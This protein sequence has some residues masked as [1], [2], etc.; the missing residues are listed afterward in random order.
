MR[1]VRNQYDP[2][3]KWC[4]F[5]PNHGHDCFVP[6]GWCGIHGH[7]GR[8]CD[9]HDNRHLVRGR[10]LRVMRGIGTEPLAALPAPA[11]L[12]GVVHL[13]DLFGP[14]CGVEPG[15]TTTHLDDVECGRCK[16]TRHY[17]S[18]ARRLSYT[19][20]PPPLHLVPS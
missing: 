11:V 3:K 13:A 9:Q 1:I 18:W 10:R 4:R 17:R 19:E 15:R 6:R 7:P 2:V 20:P 5:V 12:A 14:A 16:R 8:E